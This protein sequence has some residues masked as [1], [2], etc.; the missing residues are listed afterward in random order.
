MKKFKEMHEKVY[1]SHSTQ[2]K[3]ASDLLFDHF[4]INHFWYY[5]LT[6]TGYYSYFGT[7]TQWNEFC[8]DNA[9][10]HQFS[11]LRHPKTLKT[12]IHL[13]KSN[14]ESGFKAVLDTAWEKFKI[15]FNI[16]LASTTSFGM[17]AFGFASQYNDS[18]AD[19]RMLNE[20]PVLKLFIQNF[21]NKNRKLFDILEDSQID[22]A[23]QLGTKF[24]E[25][26]NSLAIPLEREKFLSRIGYEQF[27]SLTAREKEILKY[28]ANGFPC[29]YISNQLH[30]SKRTVESYLDKLK[31]K[32][33]CYSKTE[34]IK[35]A[36]DFAE[37]EH[38]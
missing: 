20:L 13:M 1:S 5:R 21:R 22:L 27:I 11:C 25:R 8:F 38:I 29:S 7:N 37:I 4:G 24:Y 32:L 33:D 30:L 9:M 28:T 17:E 10:L 36:K 3:S 2:L 18:Y 6:N 15:N 34:L 35:K 26:P 31:Q 14:A 23:S 19:E 12:G 16:N